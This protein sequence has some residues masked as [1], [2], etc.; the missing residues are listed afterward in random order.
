MTRQHAVSSFAFHSLARLC[1]DSC[2]ATMPS[3]AADKLH[4]GHSILMTET[5]V[6]GIFV[7]VAALALPVFLAGSWGSKGD[8]GES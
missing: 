2:P 5:F 4:G 1:T 7:A 8:T 3:K 6:F